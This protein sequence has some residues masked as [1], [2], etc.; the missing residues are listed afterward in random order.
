MKRIEQGLAEVHSDFV[1]PN[2]EGPSVVVPTPSAPHANGYSSNGH[3]NGDSVNVN[4]PGF[5]IVGQVQEGSPADLAVS[6]IIYNL[7]MTYI[8]RQ[9]Y[10][11]YKYLY[12]IN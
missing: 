2:G 1:G 6:L 12:N 11:S 5:A 10:R 3:S 7:P 9:E 8:P 4:E